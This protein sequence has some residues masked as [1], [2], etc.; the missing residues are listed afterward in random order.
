MMTETND[1]TPRRDVFVT[2]II[3]YL[4]YHEHLYY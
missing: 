2:N 4:S 3:D 1:T